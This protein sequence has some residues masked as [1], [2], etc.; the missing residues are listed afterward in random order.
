MSGFA[1]LRRLDGYLPIE[2]HGLTGD[3]ATAAL[4]G[5]DGAISWL[6]LPR[7]DAPPVFCGLLDA[8]KGGAFRVA[9][10]DLVESRQRYEDDTGVLVTEM[11]SR[12]GLV[13]V[14]DALPLRSGA[15]LAEDVPAGRRELLRWVQV[16]DGSV[17]LGV[18]VQPRGGLRAEPGGG[19]LR[20]RCESCPDLDLG[21]FASVPL[22]GPRT[23]LDLAAGDQL[24][25]LLR[26]A[27]GSA[28]HQPVSPEERLRATCDAWRRWV[29]HV[30]YEGPRQDLVRRSAI[31]LK[32]LDHFDNGAIVAAPTSSLPEIIGG[33]RN[34]D[35]RYAW[36][37][38]A[39][40]SVYA[41]LQIGLAEEAA[42]FLSWVLS[43]IERD[44][45]PR[46]LYTLDGETPPVETRD[47]D[48]EGYRRSR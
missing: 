24:T 15:E 9:P 30:R 17:R 3:G 22:A 39:A 7:F 42:G 38:D 40:F 36:I 45:R 41:L 26:W 13:R 12:S 8:E 6:C 29:G 5:R 44:G 33:V 47:P 34:W 4:V 37:R 31:T 46:V 23:V 14:T 27:P 11:R 19:G 18:D 2:D 1:P 35:Y 21:L 16:L 48:L 32:M 10:E 28:R 43:V 20:L 25:L